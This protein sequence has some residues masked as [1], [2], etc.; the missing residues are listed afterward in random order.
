MKD[1]ENTYVN[2]WDADGTSH[3]RTL[4]TYHTTTTDK[5]GGNNNEAHT[6]THPT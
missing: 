2:T 1:A 3:R 4:Q 5:H 6:K